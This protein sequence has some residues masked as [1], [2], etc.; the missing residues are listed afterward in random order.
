MFQLSG[1]SEDETAWPLPRLGAGCPPARTTNDLFAE[2]EPI[3]TIDVQAHLFTPKSTLLGVDGSAHRSH[4][5]DVDLCVRP[6]TRCRG[7]DEALVLNTSMRP[8]RSPPLGEGNDRL[9]IL[10]RS[11]KRRS[12]KSNLPKLENA[13]RVVESLFS[14]VTSSLA[15]KKCLFPPFA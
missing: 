12:K 4:L 11:E 9:R 15:T 5:L 1:H 13:A 2:S 8:V 14:H 10:C 3:P 7:R 6:T